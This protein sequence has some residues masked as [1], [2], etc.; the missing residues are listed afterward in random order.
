MLA[1][2]VSPL[3]MG[4]DNANSDARQRDSYL[5][6]LFLK[7]NKYIYSYFSA[8]LPFSHAIVIFGSSS[9]VL[10]FSIFCFLGNR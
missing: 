1:P 7:I 6:L 9:P 3:Q 8:L 4:V 2:S 10:G 5:P